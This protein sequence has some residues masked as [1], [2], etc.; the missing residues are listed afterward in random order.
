[1][2]KR[3]THTH[4]LHTMAT[5]KCTGTIATSSSMDMSH[6]WTVSGRL[7]AFLL[8]DKNKKPGPDK[9]QGALE[10]TG[11][12]AMSPWSDKSPGDIHPSL[13]CDVNRGVGLSRRSGCSLGLWGTLRC[14]NTPGICKELELPLGPTAAALH[15]K[16]IS[17]CTDEKVLQNRNLTGKMIRLFVS[18]LLQRIP[19]H[20]V[21]CGLLE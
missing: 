2:K 12:G 19:N 10:V 4:C 9:D 21:D 1:M 7:T 17:N 11:E 18:F 15:S 20:C 16:R 6:R 14:I 8:T 3:H 5:C 13:S